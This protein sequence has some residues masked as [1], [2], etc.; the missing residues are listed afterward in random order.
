MP[1]VHSISRSFLVRLG[2]SDPP[3]NADQIRAQLRR[4]PDYFRFQSDAANANDVARIGHETVENS[5][6]TSKTPCKRKEN[7][8]TSVIDTADNVSSSK[9]ARGL[10]DEPNPG[11]CG[12]FDVPIA[13]IAKRRQTRN[14][15]D[16]EETSKL[17][18]SATKTSLRKRK[19]PVLGSSYI[20]NNGVKISK[21]NG[22]IEGRTYQ[23]TPKEIDFR[24]V[25]VSKTS[26]G[27]W[28]VSIHYQGKKH[29]Y[30]TFKTL[31]QAALINEI[32]RG[33]LAAEKGSKPSKKEV[34]LNVKLAREAVSKALS[35]LDNSVNRET[36]DA[37][38]DKNIPTYRSLPK[39]PRSG[40]SCVECRR[41]K[42]GCVMTSLNTTCERCTSIPGLI[43]R[44]EPIVRGK[45][46]D[47]SL[48]A[49]STPV[50]IRTAG[51]RQTAC[52]NWEVRI[53]YQGKL[54]RMG[55][56]YTQDQ[57]ALANKNAR[58]ML[59]KT[60]DAKL[61]D[62]EIERN[63]KLA[64]EAALN[65]A[66]QLGDSSRENVPSTG[67]E[68]TATKSKCLLPKT[69]TSP[70]Q[71]I[72]FI[73]SNVV[74]VYATG[75]KWKVE[76]SYQ[77]KN[78]YGG[79]FKAK[80]QAALFNEIVRGILKTTN[81]LQLTAGEIEQNMKLAKKAGME[82]L[83][84]NTGMSLGETSEPS[85]AKFKH[86]LV[87]T[88]AAMKDSKK[89][90]AIDFRTKGV[91]QRASGNWGVEICYQG[92]KRYIGLFDTRD[93]AASA[94][95]IAR[96]MLKKTNHSKLTDGEIE[97]N[98][99]SAKEAAL[100]S[101]SWLG[102]SP[103]TETSIKETL[104]TIEILKSEDDIES[105]C[106]GNRPNL[107]PG[108]RQSEKGFE[109]WLT[110]KK[111]KWRRQHQRTFDLNI[112]TKLAAK[113]A[114]ILRGVAA[115]KPLKSTSSFEDSINKSPFN[116]T[117][118]DDSML[119]DGEIERNVKSAKDRALNT[120]PGLEDSSVGQAS[121]DVL[122]VSVE[123]ALRSPP[124]Y[125]Y[126]YLPPPQS[127][128]NETLSLPSPVNLQSTQSEPS[129]KEIE[130]DINHKAEAQAS[131]PAE[132]MMYI[133]Q[134]QCDVCHT[135]R[136]SSHDEA[137]E[138]ERDC[139]ERPHH[140]FSDDHTRKKADSSELKNKSCTLSEDEVFDPGELASTHKA[141]T[142]RAARYTLV[143]QRQ[144]PPSYRHPPPP[145]SYQPYSA[146]KP[147]PGEHHQLSP[148]YSH[149]FTPSTAD[150]TI[151]AKKDMRVP[152]WN[153]A[154][155][156]HW[157][158][159]QPNHH[160]PMNSM[161]AHSSWVAASAMPAFQ[162]AANRQALEPTVPHQQQYPIEHNAHAL[163][164][165]IYAP[166]F[167]I[168]FQ[169]MVRGPFAADQMRHWFQCGQL[170]DDLHISQ[171]CDG[172]FC[173]QS[174]FFHD[175]GVGS[176][177]AQF[178]RGESLPKQPGPSPSRESGRMKN[179]A[180]NDPQYQLTS[181]ETARERAAAIREQTSEDIEQH[182][183]FGP[184]VRETAAAVHTLSTEVKK[185]PLQIR[186]N[187]GVNPTENDAHNASRKITKLK[188]TT[189]GRWEARAHS[190]GTTRNIGPFDTRDHAVL[191]N[192]GTRG[193]LMEGNRLDLPVLYLK[194]LASNS[195]TGIAGHSQ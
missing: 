7:S 106:D 10:I 141:A 146:Q 125:Q 101:E 17:N 88:P 22:D 192:E 123:E 99:Q 107:L 59:N 165:S 183:Q 12:D 159:M 14:A 115:S 73:D 34:E 127:A 84:K 26:A 49:K 185:N 170:S 65:N 167:Y 121:S 83:A 140:E 96:E 76:C 86:P 132:G 119:T 142:Q 98:F 62:G 177:R 189:S 41:A 82:A 3:H 175:S 2:V 172:P 163:H 181:E 164:P 39:R 25:G 33:K 87:K 21:E 23:P 51:L 68:P 160:M 15:L 66:S 28:M 56:F 80:E 149:Q 117:T 5:S 139:G 37:P 147:P 8:P 176:P 130:C 191:A 171:N 111:T 179:L 178:C 157:V 153:K 174:T 42:K 36:P 143:E 91:R 43:C 120:L 55:T 79:T 136:F 81:N 135:A 19:A 144:S 93:Q 1:T 45:R 104:L 162:V 180:S 13:E 103:H 9:D 151:L 63:V 188:Q 102:D 27:K 114:T 194:K 116:L 110:D 113:D 24:T 158:L 193:K 134:W 186:T 85:A 150:E 74:G 20:W 94:N 190:Q 53:G 35:K 64:K 187:E 108:R 4:D 195:D 161:Q 11:T 32:A 61:S 145:Y 173:K 105:H 154:E 133:Q 152:S 44:F 78:R 112:A 90:P 58:E 38:L 182:S 67:L 97:R 148:C 29:Y 129:E 100:N 122:G 118:V 92:K 6:S 126:K 30:G 168:D 128:T 89:T 60:N 16:S 48:P 77:G 70:K 169:G 54:R 50:D 155:K 18:S 109:I 124:R 46:N 156:N 69:S 47:L 72:P 52:G 131:P 138:H 71:S 40:Q 95:K 31:E 184:I 57:A 137:L 75:S 166:W